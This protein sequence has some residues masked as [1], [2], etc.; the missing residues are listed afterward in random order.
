MLDAVLVRLAVIEA[1][2]VAVELCVERAEGVCVVVWVPVKEAVRLPELVR[3]G[4]P[5]LAAL[6]VLEEEGVWV[7][8]PVL[9]SVPVTDR[10][11]VVVRVR[12]ARADEE[13][14]GLVVA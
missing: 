1:V 3:L 6:T 4:V 12:V 8:E 11:C 13:R 5:V 9:V 7:S 2:T 14:L 10:V